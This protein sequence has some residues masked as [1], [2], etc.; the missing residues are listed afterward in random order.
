M[1]KQI[2]RCARNDSELARNDSPAMQREGSAFW[3][4]AN[5]G[6]E[7][8]HLHVDYG[9]LEPCDLT[10]REN[11][12]RPLSY[13]VEDKVRLSKGRA[14]LRVN[15]TLALAGIPP[16]T[17]ETGLGN[18][19]ALEWVVD[20][21]RAKEDKRSGIRSDLDR[22]DAR[23]YIARPVGQVIHLSLETVGIAKSLPAFQAS[24]V[25]RW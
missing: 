17:F 5:A 7:L 9:K 10:F 20:Q 18:R 21:C 16:E 19:S 22:A 25:A 3:A 8:A 14:S 11:R 1:V 23:E 24:S 13:H 4:F 12:T 15:D 6:K 2:P